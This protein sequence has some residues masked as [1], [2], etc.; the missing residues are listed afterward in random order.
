MKA[1]RCGDYDESIEKA[2]ASRHHSN[3][4]AAK[5]ASRKDAILHA[6]ELESARSRAWKVCVRTG[7][8]AGGKHEKLA[9]QSHTKLGSRDYMP[10][11]VSNIETSSTKELS[12]ISSE[13]PNQV[14]ASQVNNL[15]QIR[16]KTSNDSEN[17]RNE[18]TKRMR[19][20]EDLGSREVSKKKPNMYHHIE[21]TLEVV[22]P[23]SVSFSESNVC[24]NVASESPVSIGSCSSLKRRCSHMANVHEIYKKKH[25]HRPLA[26]VLES[27]AKVN[28]PYAHDLDASPSPSSIQSINESKS[29]VRGAA[30][31]KIMSFSV[32]IH[33]NSD[34][35]GISVVNND[36]ESEHI[37]A[38][39][40][41][42]I[43]S[44]CHSEMKDN[45]LS[46][47]LKSSNNDI[48]DSSLNM[49]SVGD[50][51]ENEGKVHYECGFLN[52]LKV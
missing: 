6:L 39:D 16:Q 17:N 44:Q 14:T 38:A 48:S 46:N 9:R 34:S 37:C 36:I 28:F 32:A 10:R 20:L 19:G 1:F 7:N 25:R 8:S 51:N 21:G 33:N 22:L 30:E 42:V 47:M 41:G 49:S 24:N 31:S 43:H 18:G 3:K 13:G 52:L 35:T 27:T 4:K 45:E 26:E 50:K 5:Y 29:G 40:V 12:V 15:Q 23:G 11:E 2:K